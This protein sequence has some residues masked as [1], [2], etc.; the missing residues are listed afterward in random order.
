MK[1]FSN[2]LPSA[3]K[4]VSADDFN[5]FVADSEQVL[6]RVRNWMFGLAA[7]N[8]ILTVALFIVLHH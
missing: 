3:D 7:V 4:F 6:R 1:S 8:A 5:K 2:E